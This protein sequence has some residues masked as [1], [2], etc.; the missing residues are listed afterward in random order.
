MALLLPQ[1]LDAAGLPYEANTFFYSQY[2]PPFRLT[3]GAGAEAAAW[4]PACALRLAARQVCDK[5][6]VLGR[7][8]LPAS[9][10]LGRCAPQKPLCPLLLAFLPPGRHNEVWIAAQEDAP[11]R[12][13]Q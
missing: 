1:A 10:Q 9:L 13:Q 7:I 6:M 12:Q 3:G 8:L 11:A 4:V 2:D 5:A